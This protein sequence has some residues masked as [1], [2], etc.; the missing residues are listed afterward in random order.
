[1]E[2]AVADFPVKIGGRPARM[3]LSGLAAAAASPAR[4]QADCGG[5]GGK[6]G[7]LPL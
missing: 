5:S 2:T 1:M 6:S 3:R 7:L 4:P